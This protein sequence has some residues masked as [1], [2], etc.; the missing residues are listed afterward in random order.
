MDNI[1]RVLPGQ[2]VARVTVLPFAVQAGE[3]AYESGNFW[4]GAAAQC[5]RNGRRKWIQEDKGDMH[6]WPVQINIEKKP[7][8]RW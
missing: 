5:Q 1:Q 7:F 6:F 2:V 3:N 4:R 8:K